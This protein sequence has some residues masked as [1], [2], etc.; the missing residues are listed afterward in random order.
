MK[1]E[2]WRSVLDEDNAASDYF[3][4]AESAA[5]QALNTASEAGSLVQIQPP[6]PLFFKPRWLIAFTSFRTAMENSTS[7]YLMMSDAGSISTTPAIP[8]GLARKDLGHWY[9]KAASY[10]FRKRENWKTV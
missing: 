7:D 8:D 10:R 4:W 1:P 9:G 5:R 6:Q 2:H 3:I